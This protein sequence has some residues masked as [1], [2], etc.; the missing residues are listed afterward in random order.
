M[1]ESKNK[2]REDAAS[3][4]HWGPVKEETKNPKKAMIF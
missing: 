1:K 4:G 2:K 3:K